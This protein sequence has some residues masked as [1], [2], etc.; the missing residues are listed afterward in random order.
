MSQP[1]RWARSHQGGV[2]SRAGELEFFAVS[3]L[4]R[5]GGAGRDGGAGSFIDS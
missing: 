1:M 3:L 5:S 4:V 2:L